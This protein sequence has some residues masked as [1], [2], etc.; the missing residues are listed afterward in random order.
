[1]A[2]F[3]ERTTTVV[4]RR[5]LAKPLVRLG[6]PPLEEAST[7]SRLRKEPV[8]NFGGRDADFK[9]FGFS[10]L[11]SLGPLIWNEV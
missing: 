1:M 11:V 9:K 2:K 3:Y 4:V 10:K 5:F 8:S 7:E 6:P